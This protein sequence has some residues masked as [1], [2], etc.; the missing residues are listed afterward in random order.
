[1]N[2]DDID[3][4]GCDVD[5]NVLAE[6]VLKSGKQAYRYVSAR[7]AFESST[8]LNSG[9]YVNTFKHQIL[10]RIFLRTQEVKDQLIA[11]SNAKVVVIVKNL[12]TANDETVYEVFGWD[13]GMVMSDLTQ[14]S[15]DG[16]GVLYSFTVATD[17]SSTESQLPL[18]FYAGSLAE[19]ETAI[20]ALI[21]SDTEVAD[22]S[23]GTI[24]EVD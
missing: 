12:D 1:M 20:E 11:L 23:D 13:S 4:S 10:G 16:D 7:N 14:A 22:G 5:E 21:A 9:T 19:T 15:T 3:K 17:D 24:K 18:S 2:F 8:S 6:L